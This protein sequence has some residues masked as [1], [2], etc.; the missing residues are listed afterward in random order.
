MIRTVLILVTILVLGLV[1]FGMRNS[2][3]NLAIW[4]LTWLTIALPLFQFMHHK[5]KK[6]TVGVR[7]NGGCI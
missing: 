7:S 3:W 2:L 6:V 4:W 5:D 1:S